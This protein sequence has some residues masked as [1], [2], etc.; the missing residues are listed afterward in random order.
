MYMFVVFI[1]Y[2]YYKGYSAVCQFIGRSPASAAN[3]KHTRLGDA[4][5]RD[6]RYGK[7]QA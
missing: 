4:E 5:A 6:L 1:A 7:L 2:F 3:N